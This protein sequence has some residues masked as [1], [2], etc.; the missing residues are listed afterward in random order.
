[1]RVVCVTPFVP[2]TGIDH[3]GGD[4]LT[5]HLDVGRRQGWKVSILAPSTATNA[6]VAQGDLP[7]F[8]SGDEDPL[9]VRLVRLLRYGTSQVSSRS[10]WAALPQESRRAL[11][12]ADLIDL[13]FAECYR[14]APLLRGRFPRAVIVATAHD[15]RTQSRERLAA[16]VSRR[17]R[18]LSRLTR[19]QVA[20]Y[21]SRALNAC[22]SVQVFNPDNA[23]LLLRMGVRSEV[24][25]APVP[26]DWLLSGSPPRL[27]PEAGRVLFAGAMWRQENDEAARWL[28]GRIMPR[29]WSQLPDTVLRVAG[30][31]PTRELR[32]LA[33]PRI[34]ITGFVPDFRQVYSD[35][36]VAVAPLYLGAGLKFKSLQAL[37][38]GIPIVLTGIAAEGIGALKGTELPTFD[39]AEAIAEELLRVLRSP[40]EAHR[41][42]AGRAACIGTSMDFQGDARRQWEALERR[43]VRRRLVPDLAAK[44][45]FE[46]DLTT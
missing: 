41:E 46:L 45:P 17:S 18:L 1:M 22:D 40:H 37:A 33:G 42:A 6:R 44:R 30:A 10:W 13:Q 39:T 36:T 16:S 5:R 9:A 14:H 11:G 12:D 43:C 28:I 8:R 31:R 20:R 27:D 35:C 25:V 24:T 15:V 2:H 26:A 7:L 38:V 23:D 34:E 29:V 4:Y 21:E 32:A 3:A 19:R